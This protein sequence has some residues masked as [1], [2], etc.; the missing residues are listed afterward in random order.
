MTDNVPLNRCYWRSRRGLLEL[1]LLLPPFVLA[2]FD[3]LNAS[4]R[5]ALSEL[6]EHDDHDIWDWLRGAGDPPPPLA[7]LVARIRD[8]NDERAGD[9][10]ARRQLD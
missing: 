8:F 4:E 6:L 10:R 3:A 1:D 2:N 7:D 9:G 5:H